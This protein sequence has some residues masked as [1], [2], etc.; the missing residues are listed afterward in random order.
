MEV[1]TP[2]HRRFLGREDGTYGPIPAKL[3]GL[4]GMPFNQF[5]GFYCVGTVRFRSGLNAVAFSGFACP[6]RWGVDLGL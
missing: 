6:P 5:P 2:T 1:G 4:L 3:L